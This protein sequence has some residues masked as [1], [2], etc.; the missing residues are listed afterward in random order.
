MDSGCRGLL[1]DRL[2]QILRQSGTFESWPIETIIPDREAFFSFLQERWPLFL[3]R[4]AGSVGGGLRE[5]GES[6]QVEI[7]GPTDLPFDH[8]D[9]RVYIDNLFIEGLL[10]PV[11][12]RS[13]S[14]LS[15]R[16]VAAGV[17]IDPAADRLRRL[18]GLIETVS[19]TIPG[20]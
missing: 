14:A 12:H 1:D 10:R 11:S 5:E 15:D 2:V 19:A 17:Q 20:T 3:D 16:W 18:D 9:V 8:D 6:Y 7:E 4:L 13:G